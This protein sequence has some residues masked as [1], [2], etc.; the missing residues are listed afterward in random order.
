MKVL[1]CILL[2]VLLLNARVMFSTS[3]VNQK[4]SIRISLL[5]CAPGD[6]VY[7]LFGH[8]AIRY[9][10]PQQK[11]D[12]VFNYGMFSFKTPHFLW[13]FIKGE[14]DYEL[15]VNSYQDFASEYIYLERGV[16]EQMLNL[17]SDEKNKLFQLLQENYRPQNRVYRYNYFF[18]NCATRPRDIIEESING[19]IH[20]QNQI[21]SKSFRDIVHEYTANYP[22]TRFGIDLC[23]GSQADLPITLR[24]Q[25][26]APLYLQRS[27]ESAVIKTNNNYSKKLILS[28]QNIIPEREDGIAGKVAGVTPWQASLI[29]FILVTSITIY[30]LKKRKSMWGVDLILFLSAGII[31]CILTFLANFSEHPTVSPN[32][33]LFVFHPF[34]IIVLPLI[35]YKG[36]KQ[37]KCL[38]HI[39]NSVVLTLFILLWALI[40]Q[41]FDLAVLPLALSLLIRSASNYIL[42]YNHNK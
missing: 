12:I 23:L 25:M 34:H 33:L 31:G 39:L 6:E 3:V 37:Q 5:T 16:N 38:Y 18:D 41:R 21:S 36:I 2:L 14:T 17:T 11:L 13:R 42:A 35:I 9:Q 4:D 15:G 27:F 29:L 40:P 1:R 7:S 20:Y 19:K 28:T 22:W 32:Y 26:F 10:D 8:T 30:G 24:Q